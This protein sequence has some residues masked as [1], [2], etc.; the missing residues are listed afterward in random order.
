MGDWN[1]FWKTLEENYPFEGVLRRTTGR[2]LEDLER[3]YHS[4][5]QQAKSAEDLLRVLR[6]VSDCFEYTGHMMV[7]DAGTYVSRYRN[8]LLWA[9][10]SVFLQYQAELLGSEQSRSVYHWSEEDTK[11]S[12]SGTNCSS[13]RSAVTRDNLAF[14]Y[15][16]EQSAAY[17]EVRSM[18]TSGE[19]FDRDQELLLDFFQTIEAEGYENCIIDIRRN[20]GGSDLY[21]RRLLL[22][23]NLTEAIGTTHVV[24]VKGGT[25]TLDY[26]NARKYDSM[27]SSVPELHPI[28]ELDLDNLPDLE[29]EDLEGV[30]YDTS[31]Y[32]GAPVGMNYPDTPAFSGQFW[33]LV[34]PGVYSASEMFAIFC[35]DTGF[36]PLVGQTTGGDGIGVDPMICVLPNSGIAY[37]FTTMNGLNLGGGSNQEMGTE[38]DIV[39]PVGVNALEVCLRAIEE[40]R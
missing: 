27:Y 28:E 4:M 31:V 26:Y 25:E 7:Y 1:Q 11:T 33:L 8:A 18:L 22:A 13:S 24:L 20:G 34:G 40:D 14:A 6:T 16:P 12:A 17:V 15:Y 29:Q 39:V 9:E 10:D 38:P 3:S 19:D 35:K 23:P 30:A 21:S 37:Q 32:I 36:A 2:S 5:A